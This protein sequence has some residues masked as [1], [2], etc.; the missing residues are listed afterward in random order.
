MQMISLM[1]YLLVTAAHARRAASSN[2]SD[3]TCLVDDCAATNRSGGG[4]R[5]LVGDAMSSVEHITEYSNE[6]RYTFGFA[7]VVLTIIAISSHFFNCDR[8]EEKQ[9]EEAREM[10]SSHRPTR[11]SVSPPRAQRV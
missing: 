11:P 1:N 4:A 2:H 6:L 5:G 8:E 7:V 10:L 3:S 9:H